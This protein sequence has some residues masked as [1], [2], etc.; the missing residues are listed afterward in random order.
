MG[1][2]EKPQ[3][4]HK[5]ATGHDEELARTAIPNVTV[6]STKP[7]METQVPLPDPDQSLPSQDEEIAE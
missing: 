4:T 5:P 6:D 7:P 1:K 3:K 2:Q